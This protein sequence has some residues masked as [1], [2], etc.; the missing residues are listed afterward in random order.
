M[1]AVGERAESRHE[2][3]SVVVVVQP[4]DPPAAPKVNVLAVIEWRVVTGAVA[5]APGESHRSDAGDNCGVPAGAAAR[6][7][8][9][10][11]GRREN[12]NGDG[13]ARLGQTHTIAATRTLDLEYLQRGGGDEDERGYPLHAADAGGFA[14]EQHDSNDAREYQGS[15]GVVGPAGLVAAWNGVAPWIVR[16]K[17][18]ATLGATV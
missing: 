4:G 2:V 14:A 7:G 3:G 17:H 5:I 6:I 9:K 8:G 11:Y 12:E 18:S 15:A 13:D 1:V 10:Q 16:V